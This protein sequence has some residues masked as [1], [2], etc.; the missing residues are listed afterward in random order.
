MRHRQK[1]VTLRKLT[2]IYIVLFFAD[3]IVSMVNV[4]TGRLF[5]VKPLFVFQIILG[6]VVLIM[7]LFL[8]FLVGCIKGSRK[9]VVVPFIVFSIWGGL[10]AGLP[11]PIFFGFENT[12]FILSIIQPCLFVM[13]MA[14]LWYSEQNRHWLY[15]A[16]AF[17]R[18]SFRWTRLFGFL[19]ANI[20]LVLPLVV[21]FLT[22]SLS[23][24][25]SHFSRNFLQIGLDGISVEAR[26]YSYEGKTIF[27]LPTAHIAQ[28]GFYEKSIAPLPVENTVV[29]PEGVTD[30]KKLLQ[31]GLSYEGMADTLGLETQDNQVFVAD[32]KWKP[33]DVDI[34]EFSADTIA[35]LR[36]CS[37]FYR[38]WASGDRETALHKMATAPKID[39]RLLLKDLIEYRN[40]RVTDCINDCLQTYDNIVIPWGAAHMPGIENAI[41]E[42]GGTVS[43]RRKIQVWGW[44]S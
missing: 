34:S 10:F 42:W 30:K 27:L 38:I 32:R 7:S 18:V 11:L 4:L 41:L 29:L 21:V 44:S 3:S 9:R 36:N 31:N 26:T 8:Y 22:A 37:A 2:N 40:R 28:N 5:D 15:R 13:A 20:F 6:L 39:Q 35:F 16:P 24:A 43:G 17:E 25:V 19:A 14:V 23:M 33:C 1:A 12:I